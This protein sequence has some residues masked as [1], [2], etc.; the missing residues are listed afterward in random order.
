MKTEKEKFKKIPDFFT[1][2]WLR[3]LLKICEK[4]ELE[5]ALQSVWV[6]LYLHNF[7]STVSHFHHSENLSSARKYNFPSSKMFVSLLSMKT[8]WKILIGNSI[9]VESPFLDTRILQISFKFS[10]FRS[11]ILWKMQSWKKVIEEPH[12]HLNVHVHCYH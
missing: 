1:F 11:H 6:F 3:K 4:F 8:W 7:V 2:S 9:S 12:L 10:T 5:M